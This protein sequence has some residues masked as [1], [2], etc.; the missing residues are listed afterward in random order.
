MGT[1]DNTIFSIAADFINNTSEHIFL[2]GRAGTGKTTFLKHIKA[3]CKKNV[4]VVAPT[5]VAAINAGGTTIHSFFQLPFGPYIPVSNGRISNNHAAITDKNNLL[6]KLRLTNERKEIIQQMDLLVI[7]EISMVRCDVLDAVDAVLRHVRNNPGKAFGG[8]QVLYIGDLYQLPPIVKADWNLLSSYYSNEYFFNSRAIAEKKPVYIE[9]QKVYRQDDRAFISLLNKVRDNSMENEDFDLLNNRFKPG[10]I[11]AKEDR[12]I[13]LT[14][15][16]EKADNINSKELEVLSGSPLSFK[17]SIEGDFSEKSFPADE[18]LQLKIGAQVMFLKN[19]SEKIRRYYNGKIGIVDSVEEDKIIVRCNQETGEQLIEVRR[20]VWRNIRYS[21]NKKNN[22][23][24]EEELGSFTQ[25]PLRLAWAITIHKSQGLS[26][27]KVV[28]DAGNAFAAGQ[29]YVALSRCKTLDGIVLSSRISAGNIVNNEKI[30]RFVVDQQ[31]EQLDQVLEAAR[32]NYEQEIICSLF[33]YSYINLLLNDLILFIKQNKAF[34]RSVLDWIAL[35]QQQ[36][37]T[38]L[39]HADKFINELT[40]VF[41]NEDYN[42]KKDFIYERISK[43]S[44]W[45]Y[46]SFLRMKDDINK[47]PAQT[48][49]RTIAAEFNGKLQKLWDAVAHRIHL[50][51]QEG[52]KFS[53]DFFRQQKENF[54]PVPFTVNAYSGKSE[55]VPEGIIHPSLYLALKEKRNELARENNTPIYLICSTLSIEQMAN[56]LPQ[57]MEALEMISGFGKVKSKQYGPEFV[58]IIQQFCET[59]DVKPLAAIPV[60]TKKG[61]QPVKPATKSNTRLLSYDLYK[62]GK[63]ISEIAKSRNLSTS[64]IE[65]HLSHFIESGELEITGLITPEKRSAINGILQKLGAVPLHQ[66]KEELPDISYA[67]IKWALAYEKFLLSNSQH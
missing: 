18:N 33:D 10:F 12:F 25:F 3:T 47:S 6:A 31:Q 15:H 7:D 49:N 27:E 52:N 62:S 9:L 2:T 43:A 37:S 36:F 44:V 29:V 35:L 23:I 53:V 17:A 34:S 13:T 20:E 1:A 51:N 50:L 57:T 21:F 38:S 11:A 45:F 30:Q 39:R 65:G 14:T 24:E 54:K 66:L 5:G 61:R 64:T 56:Y 48:D 59:N 4:V 19:D 67:E 28:I 42:Q 41:E 55:K 60:K 16:N 40:V 8:V 58:D 32:L 22:R 26:F 46:D 63:S